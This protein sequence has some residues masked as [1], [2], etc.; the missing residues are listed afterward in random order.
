M[1]RSCRARLGA[2]TSTTWWTRAPSGISPRLADESLTSTFPV[3]AGFGPSYRDAEQGLCRSVAGGVLLSMPTR[4]RVHDLDFEGDQRVAF[5]LG[6]ACVLR[7][8]ARW[9]ARRFRHDVA[10]ALLVVETDVPRPTKRMDGDASGS[11]SPWL[12][13]VAAFTDEEASM[14]AISGRP[15]R[16]VAR[17]QAS[18]MDRRW[19]GSCGLNDRA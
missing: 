1:A 7:A 10:C 5:W 14:N 3:S 18:S 12:G 8:D 9:V 6:E 2:T 4:C 17:A 13:R 16:A 15:A 19:P 11:S